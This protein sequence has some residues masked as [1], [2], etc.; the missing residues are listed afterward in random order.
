MLQ[1][2]E[3]FVA[4]PFHVEVRPPCPHD[5]AGNYAVFLHGEAL[6]RWK[7]GKDLFESFQQS[8]RPLGYSLKEEARSRIERLLRVKIHR[9]KTEVSR[10]KNKEW[11]KKK[12]DK[13]FEFIVYPT[14]VRQR[15]RDVIQSISEVHEELGTTKQKL[16]SVCSV[17]YEE[18][19][20]AS[21]LQAQVKLLQKDS[22][23]EHSGRHFE[24]VGER[25][26]K[27]QIQQVR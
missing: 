2:S 11:R 20:H 16:D 21:Q 25:Q 14:E 7:S 27:R 8:I 15:A 6:W 9:T 5:Q 19:A 13:W 3:I 22:E 10:S 18:M 17:L 26:Q 4:N 24:D 1:E 12:L 23:M